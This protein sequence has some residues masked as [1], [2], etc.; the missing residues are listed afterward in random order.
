MNNGED[1]DGDCEGSPASEPETAATEQFLDE[2]VKLLSA[3]ANTH[4]LFV[5]DRITKGE[6][7]VGELAAAAGVSQSTLS[8]HLA[9]LRGAGLVKTRRQAQ[10][11][12]Y[13][14]RSQA[15]SRVL[16]T[17]SEFFTPGESKA[18]PKS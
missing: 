13:T 7:S 17:L 14:C 9:I 16:D 3:M 15:V 6:T 11:V 5:L 8:Q 4:R 12:Y 1:A 18:A 10:T 2:S